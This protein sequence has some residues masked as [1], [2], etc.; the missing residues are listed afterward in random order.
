MNPMLRCALVFLLTLFLN[1][2]PDPAASCCDC[3]ISN[4]CWDNQIC[5]DDPKGSCLYVLGDGN[6]PSYAND[7]WDVCY[8]SGVDCEKTNCSS[9]CESV[10][11]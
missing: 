10:T 5:P 7:G 4:T 2:C 3:L 1:A 8:A 6:V 11:E 9:Q